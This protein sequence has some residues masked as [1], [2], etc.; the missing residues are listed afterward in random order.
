MGA[1]ATLPRE[2]PVQ[3]KKLFDLGGGCKQN[4]GKSFCAF[5]PS[6]SLT[7]YPFSE[8]I[9]AHFNQDFLKIAQWQECFDG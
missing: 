9:P 7:L 2:F 4:Q 8:T 5:R 1:A 6:W 3:T